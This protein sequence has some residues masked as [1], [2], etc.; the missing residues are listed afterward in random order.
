MTVECSNCGGIGP[1]FWLSLAALLLAGVAGW[2]AKRSADST[3][4]ALSLARDEVNMAKTEHAEF[5]RQLRARARFR[6]LP[7]PLYPEPDDD[8]VIRVDASTVRVLVEFGLKNVGDRAAGETVL[9]VL[10]PR[11]VSNFRWS[12]PRGEETPPDAK[13]AADTPEELTD[14]D[15][16]TTSASGSR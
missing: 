2:Y 16:K 3:A 10:A 1:E 5:L 7:R 13:P 6:L 4:E 9:N 14:A 12:G 11:S 15:G 8:G